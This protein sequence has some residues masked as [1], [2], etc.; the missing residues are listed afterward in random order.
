MQNKINVIREELTKKQC[1]S[2]IMQLLHDGFIEELDAYLSAE[3]QKTVRAVCKLWEKYH[4]SVTA[5]LDERK[6]AEDKLNGFL[7][8]LGYIPEK[9]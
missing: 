5:I 3:A 7:E 2:L 6:V 1:E 4:V 9:E 8:K